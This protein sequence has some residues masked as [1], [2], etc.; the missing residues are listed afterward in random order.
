MTRFHVSVARSNGNQQRPRIF[1]PKIKKKFHF[2]R[3]GNGLIGSSH[4]FVFCKQPW[5]GTLFVSS[6]VSSSCLILSEQRS[7]AF[8]LKIHIRAIYT[9]KNKTRLTVHKTRLK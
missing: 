2:S 3:M 5:I 6:K 7:I 1:P 8:I 4:H 9:R